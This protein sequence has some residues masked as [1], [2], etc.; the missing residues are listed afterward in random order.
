MPARVTESTARNQQKCNMLAIATWIVFCLYNAGVTRG[1]DASESARIPLRIVGFFPAYDSSIWHGGFYCIPAALLAVEQINNKTD[2]L[3]GYE[4]KFE[5]LDS[6]G[7]GRDTAV[8]RYLEEIASKPTPPVAIIGPGC[9]ESS[10]AFAS[11]SAQPGREVLTV[12][13]GATTPTL[14]NLVAFPYFLRTVPSQIPLADSM[15]KFVENFKW[16]A[17]A[18][19]YEDGLIQRTTVL[20]FFASL[21]R[22]NTGIDYSSTFGLSGINDTLTTENI[23]LLSRTL[24]QIQHSRKRIIFALV[25]QQ[26][27]QKLM[28]L[29]EEKKMLYPEYLWIFPELF[30]EW[31][32]LKCNDTDC[33]CTRR[34]ESINRA[35]NGS[36]HINYFF[37]HTADSV[38]ELV[39]G[40]SFS[41]YNVS[42]MAQTEAFLHAYNQPKANERYMETPYTST[43]YDAVW[44]VALGL[45]VTEQE[46]QR[47]NLSLA[48]HAENFA[49]VTQVLHR[50]ILNNDPFAGASGNITFNQQGYAAS[51]TVRFTQLHK[52]S[53]EL[54]LHNVTRES[55]LDLCNGTRES[56]LDLCNGTRESEL[57]LCNGTRESELDLCNGTRESEL[58]LCNGTRESELELKEIG[59]FRMGNLSINDSNLLW[60]DDPPVA[61]VNVSQDKA[62][63]HIAILSIT[64]LLAVLIFVFNCGLLTVNYTHKNNGDIKATSPSL[65]V[66]IFSGHFS[67][68]AHVIIFTVI[69]WMP[70]LD[71]CQYSV[72]CNLMPWTLSVGY[73]LIN[74]TV[75]LKTLRLYK[76]FTA[77]PNRK[78]MWFDLLGD[79]V[80]VIGIVYI[81]VVPDAILLVIFSVVTPLHKVVLLSS[82]NNQLNETTASVCA[83][84]SLDGKDF[85][86]YITIG[87]ILAFKGLLLVFVIFSALMLL[88]ANLPEKMALY[89]DSGPVLTFALVQLALYVIAFPLVLEYF[90]SP[91]YETKLSVTYLVMAFFP[92]A[93]VS[94]SLGCF[95]YKYRNVPKL[96]W[97]QFRNSFRSQRSVE[98]TGDVYLSPGRHP[99]L[100]HVT[101]ISLYPKQA[102]YSPRFPRHARLSNSSSSGGSFSL[103]SPRSSNATSIVSISSGSSLQ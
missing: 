1:R 72:L 21:S 11:F 87:L 65:N 99:S 36:V 57:D 27:G 18:T 10:L 86:P 54:D 81:F 60:G 77:R 69:N 68:L 67:I 92:L 79:E 70:D 56:E 7:C 85:L 76:V 45:A 78:Q 34:Q 35:M 74:G 19:L 82:S 62:I 14:S 38:D 37:G 59:V 15:A 61:I 48:D 84:S 32:D 53:S 46:L 103:T 102:M 17:V 49:N 26:A 6:G 22:L 33:N 42:L 101:W 55:E 52:V 98:D 80:L 13:Y 89:N 20:H 93:I 12:S 51:P 28:E 58:D 63:V 31:W 88:K 90:N 40:I 47:V 5:Y 100:P 24:D 3:P 2:L 39:S 91:D 41:D 29:V 83:L 43:T 96:L 73:S 23:D 50:S 94:A 95:G 30:R 71:R 8:E 16:K 4:L 97:S 64:L 75:F 9:S 66:F 44:A 25:H